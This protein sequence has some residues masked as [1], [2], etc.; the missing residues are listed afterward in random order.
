MICKRL[1]GLTAPGGDDRAAGMCRIVAA[2]LAVS[3]LGAAAGASGASS[4]PSDNLRVVVNSMYNAEYDRALSLVSEWLKTHPEDVAAWNYLAEATL[5]R[6][7]LKEGLYTGSAFL[8]SGK[9]FK[10]RRAPLP[11]GFAKALNA[12]LDQAQQLEEERLQHNPKDKE[13]LYWLGVTHSTRTEFLFALERSYFA[14]LREGKR[15][16]DVNERLLQIDPNF[17]DAY[18]VI[19]IADYAAT[20]LPWYLRMFTS[21]S[22]VHANAAR[23]VRE[24]K[25][26]SSKGR[27]TQVDAKTILIM[28]YERRGE[29][30]SAL[31]LLRDLEQEYPANYLIPLEMARVDKAAGNW[32]DAARVYDAAVEKYVRRE[33]N[34]HA[35][36]ALILFRAGEAHE[37]LGELQQALDL[38]HAAGS[39]PGQARAIYQADLAAAR[40][41]EHFSHAARARQEYQLVADSVPETDLGDAARRA[42]AAGPASQDKK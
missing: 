32:A 17:A 37:H 31:A 41:D 9:V 5:D 42:L 38:Y 27:Y 33:E 7:M 1:N 24:L 30:P 25:L 8:N 13:A 18:L 3:L 39:V 20:L 34:K 10:K 28:I 4:Q 35:P 40:L 12:A 6:E 23:G 22:G 16:L 15:A 11:R 19:G 2:V 14:A 36:R 26:A 21:L 29:Y